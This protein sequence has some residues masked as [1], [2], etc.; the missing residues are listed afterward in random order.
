M[1]R[2]GGTHGFVRPL[3]IVAAGGKAS[4]ELHLRVPR[5]LVCRLRWQTR[6]SLQM[7]AGRKSVAKVTFQTR[8]LQEQVFYEKGATDLCAFP[9]A[10]K[11]RMGSKGN[12]SAHVTLAR[13]I[14]FRWDS[15]EAQLF[16]F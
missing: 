5:Y 14:V 7:P 10:H 16:V 6:E 3:K 2:L 12:G 4:S 8:F 9:A 13:C 15:W 1:V 11:R